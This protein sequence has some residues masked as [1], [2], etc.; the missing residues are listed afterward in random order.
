MKQFL[1]AFFALALL[2]TLRAGGTPLYTDYKPQ[3]TQWQDNYILDKIEYFDNE[4]VIHFRFI[5]SWTGGIVTYYG[6]SG[7]SPWY[8]KG[9]SANY[10]LQE[11]RNITEEGKVLV[12]SLK[13]QPF[14]ER[15]QIPN[16]IYTCE[17]VFKRLPAGI[18]KV[19][20]IEGRGNE[21]SSMHF[22]AFGVSV[23]DLNS[24]DLG[25]EEDMKKKIEAFETKGR[26]EEEPVE[27]VVVEE[28]PK[29]QVVA[30][31]PAITLKFKE[32][33][34][35]FISTDLASQ[36]MNYAI[37]FLKKNTK[38]KAVIY[39]NADANL[40]EDEA[41]SISMLRAK[42]A[43]DY[44]IRYGIEPSRI[45][46]KAQGAKDLRITEKGSGLNRRIDIAF[47]KM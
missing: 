26:S 18:T 2:T 43:Q 10:E 6:V 34:D 25:T 30:S 16:A 42:R 24:K 17:V 7:A 9:E 31:K 21:S 19:D 1:V 4:M 12:K 45:E 29:P 8:L 38:Y 39:G 33:S 44:F 27:E 11:I 20:L 36:Y 5:A 13:Y 47:E 23:K 37:D 35:K 32:N 28:A 46:V 14:Y 15:T 40:K 22:N 41:Q 3:Y